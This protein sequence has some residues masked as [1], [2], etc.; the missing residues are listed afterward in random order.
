MSGN[1]LDFN[2]R[3]A[4]VYRWI[5]LEMNWKVLIDKYCTISAFYIVAYFSLRV[6]SDSELDSDLDDIDL[7]DDAALSDITEEYDE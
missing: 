2:K 6:D 5:N 1:E 7:S 4:G 3:R